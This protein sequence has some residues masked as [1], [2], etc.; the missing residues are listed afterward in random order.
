MT[1]VDRNS[2]IAASIFL[3]LYVIY[4]SLTIKIVSEKGFRSIYT[5]L[6][7]YGV[8]RVCG[9]MCGVVFSALGYEHWQWLIA[10]LVFSAEGYFVLV[11]C[12]FHL[13]ANAQLYQFGQSWFRPSKE[14]K[15]QNLARATTIREKLR[16]RFPLASVFH[17]LL[18]PANALVISGGSTLAGQD[19]SNPDPN[20]II[21]AKA[22][23]TTGQ[24]MFLSLTLIAI[25]LAIYVYYKEGVR[26]CN[27]YSIFIVAPFI[28]IRGI[29]GVISIFI[30]KMNYYDMSNYT[31]NGLSAQFVT[32][33][34][35][36]ATTMEFITACVYVGNYFIDRQRQTIPVS[37]EFDD[38]FEDK[39]PSKVD[40]DSV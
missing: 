2:G 3:V 27:I 4:L 23:R 29:F 39:L 36:L 37:N 21:T 18:I 35:V 34:Y 30:T 40:Q 26:H 8:F 15:K 38:V 11:L 16:A 33:E 31:A 13:I 20:K 19:P 10:Y 25:L 7:V 32:Y 5:S 17:I 9:Q 1:F 22:L 12:S 6:L 24:V 14:Q 28:T